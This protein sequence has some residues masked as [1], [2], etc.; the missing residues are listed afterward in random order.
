MQRIEDFS[1]FGFGKE[2]NT[3]HAKII[4][5]WNIHYSIEKFRYKTQKILLISSKT[6]IKFRGS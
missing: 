4:T 6:R 2:K 1:G 5:K 3:F